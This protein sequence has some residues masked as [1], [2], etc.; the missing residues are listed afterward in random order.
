MR[1]GT[2]TY[3]DWLRCADRTRPAP[4]T[5]P[6]VREAARTATVRTVNTTGDDPP[7]RRP[8]PCESCQH[9]LAVIAA[10]GELSQEHLYCYF[11]TCECAPV[12]PERNANENF[13]DP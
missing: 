9:A 2:G 4:R 7:R 3:L 6:R 10:R 1:P 11:I 5:V 8:E 12:Q 13:Q